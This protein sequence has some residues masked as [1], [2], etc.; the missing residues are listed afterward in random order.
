MFLSETISA[1]TLL[2]ENCSCEAYSLVNRWILEFCALYGRNA[3]PWDVFCTEK[4]EFR[5]FMLN[6]CELYV[7]EILI[8]AEVMKD[9]K[10]EGDV[11]VRNL[12]QTV[13]LS[14]KD[15]E[16]GEGRLHDDTSMY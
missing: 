8:N 7:D 1:S 2:L 16:V 9:V 15:V 5:L 12:E 13:A 14:R 4:N 3:Q 10:V 6:L 11:L